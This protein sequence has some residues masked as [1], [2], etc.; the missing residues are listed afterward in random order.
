MC[1]KRLFKMWLR[2]FHGVFKM[3][4]RGFWGHL[5]FIVSIKKHCNNDDFVKVPLLNSVPSTA[6][7]LFL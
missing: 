6:D 5:S 4:L 1:F 3:V 2:W 7:I